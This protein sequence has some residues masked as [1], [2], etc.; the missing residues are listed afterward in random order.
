VLA[1][2]G[3]LD[4]VAVTEL[5]CAL[6]SEVVQLAADGRGSVAVSLREVGFLDCCGLGMLCRLRGRVLGLGCEFRMLAVG[7]QPRRVIVKLGLSAMLGLPP[8]LSASGGVIRGQDRT[9]RQD[10][11][12]AVP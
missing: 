4:L 11:S 12:G 2:G 6:L 8:P 5:E 3:E 9:G 1:L 7:R 10:P